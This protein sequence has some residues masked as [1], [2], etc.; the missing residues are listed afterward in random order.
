MLTFHAESH[1]VATLEKTANW[2]GFLP[3][4]SSSHV[5]VPRIVAFCVLDYST[6]L[7]RIMSHETGS[8]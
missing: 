2:M 7:V 4:S 1:P 3:E 5:G 6:L 8:G